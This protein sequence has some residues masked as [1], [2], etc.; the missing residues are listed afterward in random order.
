MSGD[1][2]RMFAR[3]FGLSVSGGKLSSSRRTI[4]FHRFVAFWASLLG[5]GMIL[6]EV[7]DVEVGMSW[8]C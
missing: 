5:G 8:K 2:V 6:E 7:R 3:G 1:F 4:R